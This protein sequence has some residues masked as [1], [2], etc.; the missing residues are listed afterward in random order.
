MSRQKQKKP[1][2]VENLKPFGSVEIAREMARKGGLASGVTKRKRKTFAEAL[3]IILESQLK[4]GTELYRKTKK[5]MVALGLEGEPTAQDIPLCGML[6][7]AAKDPKAAEWLRDT[8]GEKPVDKVEEIAP[9]P[10]LILG[11]LPTAKQGD[12]PEK[13]ELH[14]D[15]EARKGEGE[16]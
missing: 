16:I 1:G 8:I 4:P 13:Y 15:P 5:T 2:R 6:Q 3:K 12:A 11:I 10:P 14:K 9:T 7:K